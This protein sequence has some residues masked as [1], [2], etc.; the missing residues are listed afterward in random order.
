MANSQNEKQILSQYL[1]DS[2]KTLSGKFFYDE[3]NEN[4]P[5]VY[6]FS[7]LAIKATEDLDLVKKKKFYGK[8]VNISS[9]APEDLKFERDNAGENLLHAA[10]GIV[11]ESGELLD[12]ILKYKYGQKELDVVNIKEELG[13]VMWYMAILLRDLNIDLYES[14]E[15]NIA[16]LRARYGEKFSSDKAIN[17]DLDTERKILEGNITLVE[18]N[19]KKPKWNSYASIIDA[20]EKRKLKEDMARRLNIGNYVE[21]I[22]EGLRLSDVKDAFG[23]LESS[24]EG[25][26]VLSVISSKEEIADAEKKAGV[27]LKAYASDLNSVRKLA[28]YGYNLTVNPEFKNQFIL[29]INF[30]QMSGMLK[31]D[32]ILSNN[33]INNDVSIEIHDFLSANNIEK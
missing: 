22:N 5:D 27:S 4:E 25:S 16:K 19:P 18:S 23:Y 33:T 24:V 9:S 6:H 20:E 13:D 3:K 17:R 28:V 8:Q 21:V 32:S 15:V 31:L 26:L 29:L 1:I 7:K 2:E 11:T 12:T 14:M 10:I 30:D